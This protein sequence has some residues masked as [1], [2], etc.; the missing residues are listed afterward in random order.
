MIRSSRIILP[1]LKRKLFVRCRFPADILIVQIRKDLGIFEIRREAFIPEPDPQESSVQFAF[2]KMGLPFLGFLKR[3]K[4]YGHEVDIR[5][6]IAL[7]SFLI[8]N[9]G[10]G[11]GKGK[12]YLAPSERFLIST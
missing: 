6:L 12:R 7:S 1:H 9:L 2:L 3:D 11:A 10:Q 4:L 8:L 5:H